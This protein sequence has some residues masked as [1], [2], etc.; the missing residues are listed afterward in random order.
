MTA[1]IACCNRVYF[2]HLVALAVVH[3]LRSRKALE[4]VPVGI[5][6]PNDIY[7]DR[8]AK[9][10]RSETIDDVLCSKTF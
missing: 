6:W 7:L 4:Q 5:K 2:Q 3:S 8:T 10:G 9:L 1:V